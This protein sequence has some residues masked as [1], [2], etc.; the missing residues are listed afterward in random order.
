MCHQCAEG[1][2]ERLQ[3]RNEMA[4][5]TAN[6]QAEVQRYGAVPCN[7]INGLADVF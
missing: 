6:T 1:E 4:A 7:T 5:L 3:G 2:W